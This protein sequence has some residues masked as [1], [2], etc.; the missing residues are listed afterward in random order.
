MYSSAKEF[1]HDA[2]LVW[3][4]CMTYN[5]VRDDILITPADYGFAWHSLAPPSLLQD[6]SEYWVLASS[7]KKI[8]D[9]KYNKSIRDDGRSNRSFPFIDSPSLYSLYHC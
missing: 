2:S 8:F 9:E 7:L 1:K 3:N 6:G 5:A 4:N